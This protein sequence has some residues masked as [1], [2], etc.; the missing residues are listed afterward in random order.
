MTDKPEDS[1]LNDVARAIGTTLGQ[2]KVQADQVIE[3]VKAVAKAGAEAYVR[4]AKR[5][6]KAAPRKKNSRAKSKSTR[7]GAGGKKKSRRKKSR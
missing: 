2:A 7:A 6:K 4:R 3:G 5:K 1:P